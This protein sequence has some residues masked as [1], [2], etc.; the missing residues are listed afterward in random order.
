MEDKSAA[1]SHSLRVIGRTTKARIPGDAGLRNGAGGCLDG[2]FL[3]GLGIGGVGLDDLDDLHD[4]DLDLDLKLDGFIGL[5][6][7]VDGSTTSTVSTTSM[8]R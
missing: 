3:V 6:S 7:R 4:L 2:E 1:A 5:D 8:R